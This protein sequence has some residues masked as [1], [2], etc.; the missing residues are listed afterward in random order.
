MNFL[1][2][3][4]YLLPAVL[5]LVAIIT[6]FAKRFMHY[7]KVCNVADAIAYCVESRGVDTTVASESIAQHVSV[8]FEVP[9]EIITVARGNSNWVTIVFVAPVHRSKT[10][11]YVLTMQVR[12][13]LPT[14]ANFKLLTTDEDPAP[15]KALSPAEARRQA[16]LKAFVDIDAKDGSKKA[17]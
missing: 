3:Y 1:L 9:R 16:L 13:F 8:L 6:Y 4:P 12:S 17:D 2:T 15:L 7:R 11:L 5:L 10:E 14:W